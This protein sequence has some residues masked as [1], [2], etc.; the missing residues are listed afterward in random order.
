MSG[1]APKG[2]VRRRRGRNGRGQ[3]AGTDR[4]EGRSPHAEPRRT[5]AGIKQIDRF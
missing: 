1:N 3:H 2:R 5:G 4:H